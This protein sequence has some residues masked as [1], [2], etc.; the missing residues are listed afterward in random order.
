MNLKMAQK[1]LP[2]SILVSEALSYQVNL[3]TEQLQ[4]VAKFLTT[5]AEQGAR[6]SC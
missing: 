2:G 5:K 1:R 4:A 6:I 3:K